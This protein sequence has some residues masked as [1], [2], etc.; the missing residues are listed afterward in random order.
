MAGGASGRVKPRWKEGP[1]G[2]DWGSGQGGGRSSL[3][4]GL[5]QRS[6]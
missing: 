6:P 2:A 3:W 5:A 4:P 1:E